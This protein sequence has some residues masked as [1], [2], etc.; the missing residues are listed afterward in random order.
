MET[1]SKNVP[2]SQTQLG[3]YFESMR[4]SG[5]VYNNHF[6]YTLDKS[7]DME[8]LAR[9]V[10]KTVQAHPYMEVRISQDDSN[11]I[12]TQSIPESQSQYQ[13]IVMKMSESQWQE[14]LKTLISEPLT[15]NGGRLF[16]FDLVETERAKYML[17]TTHHIAFDGISYQVIMNDIAAA[18][19]GEELTQETYNALD[20]AEEEAKLRAGEEL[21]LIHI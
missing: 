18:Y 12:I 3:I 2:L 14:R 10:E 6:L 5:C 8:R 4:M 16:R 7:L 21:S 11:G 15:L 20:V 13:Q 1:K 17:R 19:D 9:A